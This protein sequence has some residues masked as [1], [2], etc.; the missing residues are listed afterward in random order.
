LLSQNKYKSKSDIQNDRY[1]PCVF[2]YPLNEKENGVP[3]PPLATTRSND[4]S[5]EFNGRLLNFQP[6]TFSISDG[7]EKIT[8]PFLEET[9]KLDF[10]IAKMMLLRCPYRSKYGMKN[11]A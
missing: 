5:R 6:S 8:H 7:I 11:E 1:L 4:G 9:S 2:F 10:D 3:P